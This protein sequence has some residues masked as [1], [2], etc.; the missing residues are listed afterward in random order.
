MKTSSSQ[1]KN[2][3]FNSF[4][5]FII[6]GGCESW[7]RTTETPEFTY[8]YV[9][10]LCTPGRCSG[11]CLD[12]SGQPALLWESWL[13]NT[14]PFTTPTSINYPPRVPCWFRE[15]ARPQCFPVPPIPASGPRA[16]VINGPLKMD[17]Q[18][19]SR[20]D[21]ATLHVW[22][23]GPVSVP[24]GQPSA[25]GPVPGR[26]NCPRGRATRGHS[27][28]RQWWRGKCEW[29]CIRT[30][31]GSQL[32]WQMQN[33]QLPPHWT[34][35]RVTGPETAFLRACGQSWGWK[36]N[37]ETAAPWA[38]WG[39]WISRGLSEGNGDPVREEAYLW[40]GHQWGGPMRRQGSIWVTKGKTKGPFFFFAKVGGS[41]VQP[42]PF[43][44]HCHPSPSLL[45][46][47]P[48]PRFPF[49]FSLG[50]QA[51]A[52]AVLMVGEKCELAERMETLHRGQGQC[53]CEGESGKKS[54]IPM[55][56]EF[57]LIPQ[58][59]RAQGLPLHTARRRWLLVQLELL[60]LVE[61][62]LKDGKQEPSLWIAGTRERKLMLGMDK[63]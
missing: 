7:R 43:S 49:P 20:P 14:L 11:V 27:G 59:Q 44:T 12:T 33:L 9:G 25:W 37:C 55:S 46:L 31:G 18:T 48:A 26:T 32:R 52:W 3:F 21:L 51:S 29:R 23:P 63:R 5:F 17:T 8:S 57:S 16:L 60:S 30:P 45:S 10:V 50:P 47:L 2:S 35:L 22:P 56:P 4:S 62:W 6:H 36:G 41:V 28:Q 34:Q 13:L 39:L 15:Q 61:D 53:V 58:N 42:G 40:A 24:F 54:E 19:R 38:G 1:E